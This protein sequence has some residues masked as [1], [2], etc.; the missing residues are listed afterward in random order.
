MTAIKRV[1]DKVSKRTLI[2]DTTIGQEIQTKK[3][4]LQ[5]QLQ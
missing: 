5:S 1:V 3:Q 2:K 4:K